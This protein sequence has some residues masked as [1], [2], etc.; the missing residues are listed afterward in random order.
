MGILWD[1]LAEPRI[2]KDD[3]P[4]RGL[5]TEVW[6]QV[7]DGPYEPKFKT[8]LVRFYEGVWCTMGPVGDVRE[9]FIE[10]DTID[11]LEK[12]RTEFLEKK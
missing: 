11:R 6:H 5:E 10:K 4:I 1:R 9:L 8:R 3:E 12:L 7:Y 2:V